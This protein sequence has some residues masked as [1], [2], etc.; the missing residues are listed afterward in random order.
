M[1]WLRKYNIVIMRAKRAVRLTTKNG[2][3]VEFS[4]IMTTD[5]ASLLNQVLDNSLEEI[6]V[7]QKYLDVSPKNCQVQP[8]C[9]IELII[10]LLPETPL[11]LRGPIGCP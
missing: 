2:T 8:D 6:K 4:A 11:S 1:D 5:Q 3:T 7:V 10:D 9:D